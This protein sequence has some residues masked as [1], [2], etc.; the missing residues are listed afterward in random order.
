MLKGRGR[1]NALYCNSCEKGRDECK[2]PKGI[3]R[4]SE[5]RPEFQNNGREFLPEFRI[6]RGIP[7]GIPNANR[8]SDGNSEF[9]REF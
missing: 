2:I 1:N 8:N 7:R 4:N 5:F 6:P 3:L 9:L